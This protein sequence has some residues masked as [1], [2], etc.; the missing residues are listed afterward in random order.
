M[1]V[2]KFEIALL[3]AWLTLAIG[4]LLY[5][6]DS[7]WSADELRQL[8]SL[9]IASLQPPAADP[10]NRVADD[11]RAAEFG[12]RLF[13]DK[14][15]SSNGEVACATCHLPDR[16]FQDGTPLAKGVGTTD[17][18]TMS[19]I[20]TAHSPWQFWDG[21]K[22]SQWAQALGPL[23]S[24]V[25]HGGNRTQYA[26]IVAGHYAADYE[27]I[28]GKLPDLKHL[29][30]H[31]GPV[32]DEQ[33]K[34]AWEAMLAAD[35]DQVSTVFANMGKAI[36]AYE[37][38]LEPGRS[39]F[40]AYVEAALQSDAQAMK[41]AMSRD[42][43]A[44]LKLFVGKGQCIQCHSGPLLTNNEFHN[45][46]VAAAKGLPA[47]LGRLAGARQVVQDEFNCLSRHSDAKPE[48]CGE[49][50]FLDDN[51]NQLRQFRVP[52]LRNVAERAP[53]MHAGQL[54]TLKDVLEHYNRAPAA[55]AGHSELK[56]LGLS[57]AELRQL[58]AFLG[59]LSGPV[60]AEAKWLRSPV[61]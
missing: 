25:E 48:Q 8:R 54:A 26:H 5:G 11:P 17:R 2:R 7:P 58:E 42:E 4:A 21:R 6:G 20:G 50:R 13:F 33:A 1:R 41:Q 49:V 16:S 18:R 19:V 46:G 31:A 32:K 35:R 39:R 53:Y 27:A 44:G 15:F 55:P 45:T 59:T 40:D 60:N 10:S 14:R 56:P 38:K 23:E 28:F 36:A 61:N 22:D 52:S 47:D 51:P 24:P 43:I 9:A 30:R 37:R 29:P 57:Q 3:F 12:Q 34:A